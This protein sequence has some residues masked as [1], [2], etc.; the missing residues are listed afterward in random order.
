[1]DG[2]GQIDFSMYTKNCPA[3]KAQD[4]KPA[5]RQGQPA[6]GQKNAEGMLHPFKN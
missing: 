6:V 3:L 2:M 1:M 5:C 4:I